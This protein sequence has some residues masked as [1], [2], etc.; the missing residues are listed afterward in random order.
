VTTVE[1]LGKFFQKTPE[2]RWTSVRFLT[3]MWLAK[4]T[5]A[6]HRVHLALSSEEQLSF[7][8]S[9]FPASFSPDRSA[10]EYWGEDVGDLRFLWRYLR[11]GM[12]FLD[13]GA[14]H[15]VYSL[16]AAKKV[17]RDG[18]VVAFEPSP[19]ER[20]RLLLHLWHNRIRSVAVEPFALAS[21]EGQASLT[22]VV[23]GYTTMN[24]LRTPPIDHP[25]SRLTVQ[26]MALD[27]Y[28][29]RARI[30]RVDLLKI[31]TEGGEMEA[32]RGASRLLSECRPVVICE[33]FDL[34][35][36]AWGYAASDIIDLLRAYDYDWCEVRPDGG[37]I[38]HRCR[39]EYP[40]AKNYV[41]VPREKRDFF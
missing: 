27:S 35:T 22:V 9:Y 13:I 7:W 37:L 25:T 32:F 34:V 14:H 39:P 26:T 29:E 8:W 17:G 18:R 24:S 2:Q 31:D 41:A 21:E 38:P 16:V 1:R 5:Y 36:R 19:R 33:V 23:E 15:G 12:T 10:F 28:L 30:D 40:S 6:P 3:T 11:P 4:L 20:R